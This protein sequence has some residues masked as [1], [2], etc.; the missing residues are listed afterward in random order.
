MS[1]KLLITLTVIISITKISSAQV[2][3]QKAIGGPGSDYGA[4]VQQTNDGGYVIAGN[5]SSFGAGSTDAYL[6]RT[7]ANGDTLWTKTYGGT[8]ADMASC[9]KQTADG[10]FIMTGSTTSFGAGFQDVY[11]IKTDGNGNLLW[12]KAYGGALSDEGFSVQQTDDG[13]YIIAGYTTS[14][15][16]GS[17]DFYL[18]RTNA[19]GD[20][21]WTR[22]YGGIYPEWCNSVEQTGDAGYIISGYTSSFGSGSNDIYLVKT[23]SAGNLQWSKTYGG[24]S[25]DEAGFIRQTSDGGYIIGGWSWNFASGGKNIYVVKT[26]NSGDT[27]WSR[28]YDTGADESAYLVNET[29]DGGYIILS[30]LFLLKTGSS[31]NVLWAKH[32]GDTGDGIVSC[33]EASDGGYIITGRKNM[34]AFE[35]NIYFLKTDNNGNSGCTENNVLISNSQSVAT[36]VTAALTLVAAGGGMVTTPATIMGSGGTVNTSCINVG[37]NEISNNLLL[38]AYPNPFTNEFTIKG[39]KEKGVAVLFDEMGKELMRQQTFDS[40]TKFKTEDLLPGFYLLHY[41]EENK[42]LNLKL[43][44]F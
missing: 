36:Q 7:N 44:K 16:A 6:I 24:T 35:Y 13:G 2:T 30:N 43:S 9:V 41:T 8:D 23:D 29:N 12:S 27:L 14:F 31:G 10:G 22:T 25:A 40:E 42:T 15:G 5:T 34:G 3:F 20:S 26:D 4:S 37:I 28:I 38:N 19:L 33:Q 21:L 39:T 32:Y 18:I 1:K 17:N 11:L